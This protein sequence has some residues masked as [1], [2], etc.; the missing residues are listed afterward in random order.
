MLLWGIT[1]R[2]DVTRRVPKH[3]FTRATESPATGLQATASNAVFPT[4]DCLRK[5]SCRQNYYRLTTL[6]RDLRQT[7]EQLSFMRAFRVAT[8]CM[9]TRSE[10]FDTE[11]FIGLTGIRLL[12]WDTS[13]YLCVC[14]S[15]C[16]DYSKVWGTRWRTWLRH[17]A[18]NRKVAG[19][20]PDEVTGIFQ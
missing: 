6:V 13:S 16:T 5:I 1:I 2:N 8:F 15:F 7:A 12:L 10:M 11:K 18:T 17:C 9:A 20:I 3:F 19:S 4:G 14:L